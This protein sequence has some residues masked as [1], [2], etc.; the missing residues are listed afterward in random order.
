MSAVVWVLIG[1]SK[2][3]GNSF[4]KLATAKEPLS[5]FIVVSRTSPLVN[6][7]KTLETSLVTHLKYD[8]S[9][10]EDQLEILRELDRLGSQKATNLGIDGSINLRIVYFSGGGPHGKFEDK[11]FKDHEWAWQ[12]SFMAA[13]RLIHHCYTISAQVSQVCVIGSSVSENQPEP[14]A[15]SYAVAK[16]ALASL[17]KELQVTSPPFDLRLFSPGYMNTSM[18]PPKSWPR[19][20][21]ADGLW[22]VAQVA[23]DLY[24]WLNI[25]EQR[26]GVRELALFKPSH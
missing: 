17:V 15:I 4:L 22:S 7:D 21:H 24:G 10:Q 19:Q 12:V 14:L 6:A 23:E 26:Q 9:K 5:R 25:T 1:A 11:E 20:K 13:A 2:G 16:R 18:L 3:L 8:L